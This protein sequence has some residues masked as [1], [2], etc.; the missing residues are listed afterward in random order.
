M[1]CQCNHCKK[2]YKSIDMVNS[3]AENCASF[4]KEKNDSSKTIYACYGSD[5]DLLMFEVLINK[6]VN[7][8]LI[9]DDC[10]TELTN[11]GIII[12]RGEYNAFG[13]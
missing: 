10:I 8:G 3:Q 13:N 2:E 6:S 11:Q 9:C 4:V 5:Y 12:E 1:F 7:V